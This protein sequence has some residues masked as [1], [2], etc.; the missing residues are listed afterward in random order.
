M[1]DRG[2]GRYIVRQAV[3]PGDIAWA[4]TLRA[5]CFGLARARDVDQYDARS[6][7]ILI[8]SKADNQLVC[9]FR[10]MPL[11]GAEISHSYSAQFYD[12]SA[13]A[14]FRAPMVEI[15]R[16]CVAPGQDDPDILRLALGALTAYVDENAVRFIIGCASFAGVDATKYLDSFAMLKTRHLAPKRWM[17]KIKAP[18][19]FEYAAQVHCNP[20]VKKARLQM[21]QLLRTYLTMG[22][23]VSDHA[24]IDREMNTMHVFTGV[25][26]PAIPKARKRSLRA[27][28]GGVQNFKTAPA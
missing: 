26:I 25:E 14:T 24:V 17:P 1:T 10:M 22:A 21:P 4:Q 19:V 8:L 9:C 16:F 23:W 5:R 18:C 28:A 12:L 11:S 20:D 2:R 3:L 15:G 6:A 7:H 27:V 13:F